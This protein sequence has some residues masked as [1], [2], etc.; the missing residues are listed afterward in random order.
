MPDLPDL[1]P[2]A[3]RV[4]ALLEGV[5]DD[6]LGRPTPCEYDVATLLD[7]LDGLALAFTLAARKSD[8]PVLAAPPAPSAPCSTRCS[9]CARTSSSRR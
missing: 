9:A 7:H 5:D 3:R 6:A 1:G 8:D 2:A 4:S